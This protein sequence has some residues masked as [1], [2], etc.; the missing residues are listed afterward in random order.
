MRRG[1]GSVALGLG[2]TGALVAFTATFQ[3]PRSRFWQRMTFTGAGLGSF[4]LLASRRSRAVRIRPIDI[5]VGLASAGAL[6]PTKRAWLK[7]GSLPASSGSVIH[8]ASCSPAASAGVNV[9]T[10]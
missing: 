2:L 8:T 4:A 5:P 3:G 10:S 7:F 1:P 6:N 9:V